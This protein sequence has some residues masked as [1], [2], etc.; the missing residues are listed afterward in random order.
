MRPVPG[1]ANDAPG[2]QVQ[3]VQIGS[4]NTQDNYFGVAAVDRLL[5]AVFDHE[6][7]GRDLDLAHFA[8]RGWLIDRFDQFIA[9]QLRGYFVVQKGGGC[10]KAPWPLLRLVGEHS[11]EG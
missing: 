1:D 9:A 6:S 11:L 10:S 3:G 4:G 2:S 5:D 8:G 7:L